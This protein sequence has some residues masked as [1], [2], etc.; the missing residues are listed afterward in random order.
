V[1]QLNVVCMDIVSH[2]PSYD[3]PHRVHLAKV[4]PFKDPS[5]STATVY[6]HETGLT[7]VW[8]GGPPIQDRE[9]CDSTRTYIPRELNGDLGGKEQ[10]SQQEKPEADEPIVFHL[11]LHMSTPVLDLCFPPVSQFE[12]ST[13]HILCDYITVVAACSDMRVRVVRIPLRP[14]RVSHPE[15]VWDELTIATISLASVPNCVA[16]TW[17]PSLDTFDEPGWEEVNAEDISLQ[18]VSM[19]IHFDLL[20]AACTQEAGGKL[21]IT[22]IP[23]EYQAGNFFPS[24]NQYLRNAAH[25]LSFNTSIYPSEDH[26]ALLISHSTCVSVYAPHM[27]SD[28]WLAYLSTPFAISKNMDVGAPILTQRKRILDAQW[29]ATG[30]NIFVLLADGEWGI[31]DFTGLSLSQTSVSNSSFMLHGY[32]GPNTTSSVQETEFSVKGLGTEGSSLVPMTSET[33]HSKEDLIS[34]GEEEVVRKISPRGGISL[35]QITSASGKHI[36]ESITIWYNNKIYM[37]P[38]LQDFWKHV[39]EATRGSGESLLGPRLS[40]IDGVDLFG[41]ALTSVAQLPDREN[42]VITA[43]HKLL[44]VSNDFSNTASIAKLPSKISPINFSLPG[45]RVEKDQIL[46][47]EGALD[48]NGLGRLLDDMKGDNK[49]LLGRK[50]GNGNETQC[51]V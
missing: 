43:E 19:P 25:K 40:R 30:Q 24:Q 46:L 34:L 27:R 15:T 17:T 48:L 6:G 16:A 50:S 7:V 42:L 18:Q 5:G 31:W 2:L 39:S 33:R 51:P 10:A 38:S 1:Y 45:S 28:T 49:T 23:L 36:K 14:E 21:S 32:V 26:T 13:P 29:I 41:E 11:D 20:V 8:K 35:H 4:Y 12:D 37:I 44:F 22:R 9:C 3:L 47:T